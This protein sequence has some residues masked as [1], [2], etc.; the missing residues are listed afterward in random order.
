M[1]RCTGHAIIVFATVWGRIW[2][3]QNEFIAKG[4]T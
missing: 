3:K 1:P 2:E 4:A